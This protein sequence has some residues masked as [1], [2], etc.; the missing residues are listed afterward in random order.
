MHFHT[1]ESQKI[2]YTLQYL[3]FHN[4]NQWVT[5][6]LYGIQMHTLGQYICH[7]WDIFFAI[8]NRSIKQTCCE[9]S[10]RPRGLSGHTLLQHWILDGNKGICVHNEFIILKNI[11]HGLNSHLH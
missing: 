4:G 7:K 1:N 9:Q 2:T 3:F 10:F 6:H 11:L 5:L 8:Y